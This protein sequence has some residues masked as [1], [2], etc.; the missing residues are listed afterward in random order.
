MSQAATA[1]RVPVSQTLLSGAPLPGSTPTAIGFRNHIRSSGAIDRFNATSSMAAR[2]SFEDFDFVS[3][4]FERA[5]ASE[6]HELAHMLAG[7]AIQV[8]GQE[9]ATNDG[10]RKTLFDELSTAV[11]EGASSR[12]LREMRLENAS[13]PVPEDAVANLQELSRLIKEAHGTEGERLFTARAKIAKAMNLRAMASEDDECALEHLESALRIAKK[14]TDPV[15]GQDE[16]ELHK[17]GL[18]G[19]LLIVEILTDIIVLAHRSGNF[20]YRDKAIGPTVKPNLLD[21]IRERERIDKLQTDLK[22]QLNILQQNYTS[23]EESEIVAEYLADT[24]ILFS[25]LGLPGHAVELG[26]TFTNNERFMASAAAERIFDED[27]LKQFHDESRFYEAERIRKDASGFAF[28]KRI[29]AGLAMS[30]S[31][32][33]RVSALLGF[34]GIAAGTAI[35]HAVGVDGGA[36]WGAAAGAGL[37]GLSQFLKGL[38]SAEARQAGEYGVFD[39]GGALLGGIKIFAKSAVGFGLLLLPAFIADA[40][41]ESLSMAYYTVKEGLAT[42]ADIPGL[43]GQLGNLFDPATYSNAAE[44][45]WHA[46]GTGAYQ[47]LKLGTL[48]LLFGSVFS[49]KFRELAVKMNPLLFLGACMISADI[50]HVAGDIGAKLDL[51]PHFWNGGE[52]G[53]QSITRIGL[54]ALINLEVGFSLMMAG[55][56]KFKNEHGTTLLEALQESWK[57]RGELDWRVANAAAIVGGLI[58]AQGGNAIEGA[59]AAYR[60]FYG[61]PKDQALPALAT[62]VQ[63]V[64]LPVAMLGYALGSGFAEKRL[65]LFERAGERLKDSEDAGDGDLKQAGNASLGL[66]EGVLGSEFFKNRAV[67]PFTMDPVPMI[68]RMIVGYETIPGQLIQSLVNFLSVNGTMTAAYPETSGTSV[69]RETLSSISDGL[70]EAAGRYLEADEAQDPQAKAEFERAFD[71]AIKEIRNFNKKAGQVT[72]VTHPLKDFRFDAKG[73]KA[74]CCMLLSVLKAFKP[75]SAPQRP[76]ATMYFSLFQMLD[77]SMTSGRRLNAGKMDEVLLDLMLQYIKEDARDKNNTHVLQPLV[78]LLAL[79]RETEP[80]GEKLTAFFEDHDWVAETLN[81]DLDNLKIPSKY[82]TRDGKPIAGRMR[83]L[84]KQKVGL[85]SKQYRNLIRSFGVQGEDIAGELHI[86]TSELHRADAES[87]LELIASLTTTKG[88]AEEATQHTD[89]ATNTAADK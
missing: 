15:V 85:N 58:I 36:I 71:G 54:A 21:K 34:G 79:A 49:K 31:F 80:F 70:K 48:A 55:A 28:V 20:T 7:K 67:R 30:Q 45:A 6:D 76:N 22:R 64:A 24:A 60:T 77:H 87:L 43:V 59:D 84:I 78:K 25:R 65:P 4:A 56:A 68:P 12:L 19:N 41:D 61:I 37:I 26:R 83:K 27:G 74:R 8:L 39:G 44:T 69:E 88:M 75:V 82:K 23:S 62:V 16:G 33:L 17:A 81:V 35:G 50:G 72:D 66:L 40:S 89:I 73:I 86:D 46:I 18:S 3:D 29:K 1:F 5:K 47:G 63:A 13:K 51:M 53:D 32:G 2:R 57:R 38:L 11:D 9:H 14:A 52:S 42:Y 10:G